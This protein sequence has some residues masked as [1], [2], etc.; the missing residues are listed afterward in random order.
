[1]MYS[2]RILWLGD[3]SGRKY[4]PFDPLL[5][6]SASKLGMSFLVPELDDSRSEPPA[7][8]VCRIK[9]Y[10][11]QYTSGASFCYE[12]RHQ[13]VVYVHPRHCPQV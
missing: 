8:S 1:M 10:Q 2:G 13:T 12:N 6:M 5:S 4:F 9:L 3:V 11:I 7:W